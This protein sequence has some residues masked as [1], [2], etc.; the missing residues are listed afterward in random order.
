MIQKCFALWVAIYFASCGFLFA[1]GKILSQMP[2]ELLRPGYKKAAF[3]VGNYN[4]K[5]PSEIMKRHGQDLFLSRVMYQ[6]DPA[7]YARTSAKNDARILISL[8]QFVQDYQK[9]HSQLPAL[10]AN[11]SS[12]VFK[13]DI[14]YEKYLPTDLKTLY[15]GE[16]H[17]IPGVPHE[18]RALL[19]ALPKLY[20]HRPIYLA[21][22]FVPADEKNPFS[23]DNVLTQPKQVADYLQGTRRFVR[24]VL[25]E[26]VNAGIGVIGL[27]EEH[28]LFRK[29]WREVKS[30]PNEGQYIEYATSFDGMR[31]RN[32]AWARRLRALRAAQPDALIVVYAGFAHVGYHRD[33]SLPRLLGKDAFV[34]LFTTPDFLKYN[35]PLFRYLREDDTICKQFRSSKNAKLVESWK[36]ATPL[37]KILGADMTVIMPAQK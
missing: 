28:A 31:F 34:M 21:T 19:R 32:R 20:P 15:L 24:P 12:Q 37:K 14:P 10:A 29:V 4:I 2:K 8:R 27:E 25:Y 5:L 22:E 18:V 33:F 3:Q 1:Q 36:K 7:V 6:L 35:N 16:V 11:I 17:N 9:F 23:L 26:A 13:G 30:F